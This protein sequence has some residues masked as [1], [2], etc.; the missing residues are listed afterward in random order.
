MIRGI[1]IRIVIK[2]DAEW[3]VIRGQLTGHNDTTPGRSISRPGVGC[4]KGFF[5]D[6]SYY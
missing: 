1:A 4:P 6:F 2:T 3:I 5:G